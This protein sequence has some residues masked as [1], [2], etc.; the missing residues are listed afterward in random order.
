MKT[1]QNNDAIDHTGAVY[2]EIGT[3]QS[4]AI[5]QNAIIMKIR[6]ENDV[7]DCTSEVYDKNDIGL[8]HDWLYRCGLRQNHNWTAMTDRIGYGLC[9]RPDK[10]TIWL[11]VQV[12]STSK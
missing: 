9:R 2:V 11:I 12:Q 6:Q 10:T 5:G 1:R 3:E 8:R 7:N 4:W